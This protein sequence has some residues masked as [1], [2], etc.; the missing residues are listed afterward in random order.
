MLCI[1]LLRCILFKVLQLYILL[2]CA[3]R[4]SSCAEDPHLVASAIRWRKAMIGQFI[5]VYNVIILC[6]RNLCARINDCL[7]C[8]GNDSTTFWRY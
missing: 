7:L 3:T 5:E 2:L 1:T 8:R 4:S 6:G